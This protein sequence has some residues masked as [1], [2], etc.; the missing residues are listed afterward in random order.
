MSV[1]DKMEKKLDRLISLAEDIKSECVDTVEDYDTMETEKSE[2]EEAL[3]TAREYYKESQNEIRF[4]LMYIS[5]NNLPVPFDGQFLD[6]NELVSDNDPLKGE[7]DCPTSSLYL[8]SF[9]Y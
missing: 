5:D 1:A 7:Y 6:I 4:L 8:D 9:C 3:N 2:L